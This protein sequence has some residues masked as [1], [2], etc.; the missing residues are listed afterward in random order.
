MYFALI[1]PIFIVDKI[2]LKINNKPEIKPSWKTT[3]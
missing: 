1:N 2:T 3:T